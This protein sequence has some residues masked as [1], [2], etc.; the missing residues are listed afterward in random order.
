[1]HIEKKTLR[2]ILFGAISCIVLYWILIETEKAKVAYQA[3]SKVLSPFVIGACIAF[4]LNV[5]MRAFERLLK[6]VKNDKLRRVIAISLTI[7]CLAIVLTAVFMLLIPQLLGAIN[8]LG[9]SVPRFVDNIRVLA[10][11][12]VNE[13]K[14]TIVWVRDNA[15]LENLNWTGIAEQTAGIVGNLLSTLVSSLLMIILGL[16][17]ALFD[18]FIAIVFAIYCLFQKETLARQGRKLLYAFTSEKR[19]DS[20]VRV[21]RLTNSTFSNFLSGQCIEVCILGCMFAIAMAICRMPYIP[22]VSVLIAVTAFIPIVGA[23]IGCA[24]GAFLMFVNDPTSLQPIWFVVLSV[25][26]QQLE[27]NVIYPKVVG[28]SI[29]LSGMWVLLAVAVGGNMFGVA[30]M[31]L[32]IPLTSVIYSVIRDVTNNKLNTIVI[33]SSKLECQPPEL[34]PKF[35]K[36]RKNSTTSKMVEQEDK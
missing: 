10:T 2:Y 30:G 31:F 29:G 6:N 19:A 5:P 7:V 13:N 14:E 8:E 34:V 24:V 26:V 11:E 15:K 36:K 21:L 20:I 17:G 3:V 33:D 25:V 32:M 12:F 18:A 16:F 4:I 35:T 23:W 28:T 27:N 9:Q 1:M 22:L